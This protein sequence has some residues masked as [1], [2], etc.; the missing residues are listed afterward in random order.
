LKKTDGFIK[1]NMQVDFDPKDLITRIAQALVNHPDQVSV[2]VIEDENMTILELSVAK[3]DLGKII[4]KHGRTADA[5]RTILNAASKK[6]RKKYVLHHPVKSSHALQ[7][8]R[9]RGSRSLSGIL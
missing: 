1:G 3:V 4:G 9:S 2:K 6:A 5:I 8:H 7:R